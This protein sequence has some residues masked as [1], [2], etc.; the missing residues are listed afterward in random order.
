VRVAIRVDA[1]PLIGGGHAMRCL[2]L[3]NALATRGAQTHFVT[4]QMPRGFEERIIVAGHSIARIAS[5]TEIDGRRATDWHWPPLSEAVQLS[6]ARDT[7]AA[8]GAVDWLVVDHYLLGRPWHSRARSFATNVLAIDDL[9]NRD[10]DCDLLVDQTLGRSEADYIA[11]VPVD[12]KVLVGS[13]YALLRP[14][15]R[16]ERE[17]ALKYRREPKPVQRILVSMGTT[18]PQ[19]V[20]AEVVRRVIPEAPGASIDVVL[21]P[22]AEITAGVAELA[23]EYPNVSLALNSQHM[24]ELMRK[25]D[26]AIGA[27]GSMNWE[28][29]CLGLPALLLVLAENQRPGAAALTRAGAAISIDDPEDL[30]RIL[31]ELLPDP[32]R[33][34]RMS[35]AAFAITDGLGCDRVT[36]AMTNQDQPKIGNLH[37]RCAT[38]KD[39]EALWL[40]RNDP[41]AGAQSRH[42]EPIGWDSHVSWLLSALSSEARKIMVAEE[43]GAPVGVVAVRALDASASEISIN[44]APERRGRGA[45]QTMLRKFCA[46]LQGQDL[47]ATVRAGNAASRRL[48]ESCGFKLAG[49]H[50]PGFVRYIKP[51]EGHQRKQA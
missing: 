9:A 47:H 7:E 39:A 10:Y 8:S 24:A 37:L 22:Q 40:W 29:A 4:A 18:D 49:D 41:I 27:S 25:S 32:D 15:F 2:A 21:G 13:A 48:F 11:L 51:R 26:L 35:A 17:R 34:A 16:A 19:G 36:A 33:L 3:A 14:E 12:A 42:T 5:S 45:G 50:E 30:P 23:R 44:V 6:D 43:D 1:G 20:S 46:D 31:R 38:M 28:R